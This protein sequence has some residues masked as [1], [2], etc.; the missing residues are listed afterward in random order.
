MSK[1]TFPAD[2]NQFDK[3]AVTMKFNNTMDP[4]QRDIGAKTKVRAEKVQIKDSKTGKVYG[5]RTLMQKSTEGVEIKTLADFL[6]AEAT[7]I[8]LLP[9]QLVKEIKKN[10]RSRAA[11]MEQNWANALELVH[12]AYEVANVARPHP[13]QTGAWKQYEDVLKY[14]VSQLAATRGI[15]GDWRMSK[16]LY[17]ESLV[18]A[19][20]AAPRPKHI[21]T[22]RFFVDIPGSETSEVEAKSIDEIIE[23][24]TNNLRRQGLKIRIEERTKTHAVLAVWHDDIKRDKIVI[25]DVS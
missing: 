11:D 2:E 6:L 14:A 22:H 20:R 13:E 9:D 18:E 5:T 16:V 15:S 21:G 19:E 4:K 12:K 24:L 3:T 7:D 1:K 17:G 10:I 25:K 8:S 23:T